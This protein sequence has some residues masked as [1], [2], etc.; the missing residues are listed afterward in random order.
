MIVTRLTPPAPWELYG[1]LG[2][3]LYRK[4]L[5]ELFIHH[6][7]RGGKDL[8]D[9]GKVRVGK[10]SLNQSKTSTEYFIMSVYCT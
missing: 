1:K 4:A 10:D 3:A 7:G 5:G 9:F 8:H 6:S 2:G